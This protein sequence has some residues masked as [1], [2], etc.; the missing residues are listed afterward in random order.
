M[1]TLL[2]ERG[3]TLSGG[4]K[5]RIAIARALIKNPDI[6]LMDDCLSAIDTRTEKAILEAFDEVLRNKT[7]VLITHRISHLAGFT[8]IMVLHKG[9][10]AEMGTHEELLEHKGLYF[11]LM[12]QQKWEDSKTN[13]KLAVA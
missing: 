8:Q 7:A 5:Q 1:K 9:R 2:G 6:L 13:G 11:D 12:E 10:L 4:Q 3:V